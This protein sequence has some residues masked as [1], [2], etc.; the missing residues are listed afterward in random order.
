MRAAR[1]SAWIATAIATLVLGC[2]PEPFRPE[3]PQPSDARIQE[4]LRLPVPHPHPIPPLTTVQFV[5]PRFVFQGATIRL[6]C[7]VPE[8]DARGQVRIALDGVRA[9]TDELP[10]A[11]EHTLLVERVPCGPL[12]ATCLVQRVGVSD[13]IRQEPIEVKGGFC[14]G[15]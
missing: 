11:I 5:V 2:R 15:S 8:S 12:T 4:L 10:G 14:E 6:R 9:A 1:G 3:V 13:V 7:L